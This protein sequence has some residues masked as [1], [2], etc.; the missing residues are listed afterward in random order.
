[1]SDWAAFLPY[2]LGIGGVGG[3]IIGI[4]FKKAVRLAIILIGGLILI[5][6]YLG[7]SGAITVNYGKLADSIRGL[8]GLGKEAA[9]WLAPIIFN[10]PLAG[11]FIVGFILGFKIG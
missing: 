11:S 3:F 6:A 1:M 7:F 8:F 9:G 4:L 10:L 5:L 2:Q